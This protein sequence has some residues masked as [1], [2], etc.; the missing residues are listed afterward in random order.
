MTKRDR[1]ASCYFERKR[2]AHAVSHIGPVTAAS[3]MRRDA[4]R[5]VASAKIHWCKGL[6]G[7]LIVHWR[8]LFPAVLYPGR[9]SPGDARGFII[10]F[11]SVLEGY[12]SVQ[13]WSV[14]RAVERSPRVLSLSLLFSLSFFPYRPLSFYV[15]RS[16]EQFNLQGEQHLPTYLPLSLSLS[17]SYQ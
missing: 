2:V 4:P 16:I 8:D 6:G 14:I 12:W 7:L 3:W 10:Q 9:V 13:T 1:G 5:R 17:I 15:P 11:N